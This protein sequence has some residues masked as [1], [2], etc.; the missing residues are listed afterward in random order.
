MHHFA[1]LL[2]Y[3]VSAINPYLAFET[4]DDMIRQGLLQR[5]THEKAVKNFI[6]AATKGVVKILSKMGISTIQS[7][8]G[9]QIFEAVGLKQELVDEYFTWTP[10]RIGGIGLD[11]I[12]EETLKHHNRAFAEQEG[13]VKELDSGGEYQWRKDGED[14]LFSPQTIHTLQMAS[15]TNDYKLYKKFSALVQGEDK[16]HLTL[17]SLLEF[18]YD[19]AAGAA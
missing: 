8:R 13:R 3:G 12:A 2:G 6:K 18:N 11:V 19:A 5:L 7:Y 1:L 17:R 4:L 15:R 16:K 9:A 10:S 14:H